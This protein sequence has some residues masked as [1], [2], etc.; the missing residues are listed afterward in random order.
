[1]LVNSDQLSLPLEIIL[2]IIDFVVS[3]SKPLPI[4]LVRTLPT[5]RT[6]LSLTLTS[7]AIYPLA[8]RLLYTHCM[9]ISNSQKLALLLRTLTTLSQ[10][11]Q[12][13]QDPLP[14]ITSLYLRPFAGSYV[15]LNKARAIKQLL[16]IVGPT[17]RRLVIDMPLRS[18][19]PEDDSDGIR[20][21]LRSA[22]LDLPALEEFCSVRDE[23]YLATEARFPPHEPPVWSLWPK[24]KKL[25]LYNQDITA[26][27]LRGIRKL[28]N[29]ETLVL[30]RSDG[31][32]E[33][34]LKQTWKNQFDDEGEVRSLDILLANVES[35]H[36][37]LIGEDRWNEDDRLKVRI[38]NVPISYYGDEDSIVACQQYVKRKF[39]SGEPV[40][41]WT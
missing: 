39:L 19:Y 14:S 7:R 32:Y 30:T 36:P 35:D 3:S 37:P 12:S 21:V 4:A 15:E 33:T 11:S 26:D 22:F 10:R 38:L 34:D 6:L 20:P 1:M 24:L 31:L 28:H 13:A 25:A 29:I 17:L 40:T 9:Y 41:N 23:L 16:N 2:N 27:F 18:L 8:R 5:T